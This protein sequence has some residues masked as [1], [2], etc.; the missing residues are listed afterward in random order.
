MLHIDR[1]RMQLPAGYEHRAANIARL[2]GDEMGNYQ[3]TE[4]QTLDRLAIGPMQISAN[5]TDQQIAHSIA[6]RIA[7]A[8]GSR[9]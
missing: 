1:M 9:L 4:N 2:L 6:E 8:L 7:A 3:A 5:T